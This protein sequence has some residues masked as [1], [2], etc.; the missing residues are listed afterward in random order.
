MGEVITRSDRS[1]VLADEARTEGD[2]RL[3]VP[4]LLRETVEPAG[5]RRLG[6]RLLAEGWV[7]PPQLEAALEAKQ[8][9]GGFLGET[10][11]E[12]GFVSPTQLGAVLADIYGVPY[13]DLATTV[14]DSAAVA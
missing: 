10:L 6:E 8:R 9:A 4:S 11:L 14:I 13:V 2:T 1:I 12:M 5:V 7:T 3:P